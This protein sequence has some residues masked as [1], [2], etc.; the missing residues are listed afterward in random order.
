MLKATKSKSVICF[1]RWSRKAYAVFCSL[2]REV[3]IGQLRFNVADR[4]LKKQK[5]S[6]RNEGRNLRSLLMSFLSDV[7]FITDD[8]WIDGLFEEDLLVLMVSADVDAAN[9]Y[10]LQI[11][12]RER[13]PV[14][15]F[16]LFI[17]INDGYRKN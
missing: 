17:F 15:G 1:R 3:T 13:I 6:L 12:N 5:T 9:N 7:P 2:K 4:L 10:K 8:D 11:T 14:W 16:S